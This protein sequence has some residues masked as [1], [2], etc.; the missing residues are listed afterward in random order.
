ML[1]VRKMDAP[2]GAEVLDIDL[3]NPV[4]DAVLADIKQAWA[5]HGIL[6]F[7]N[8]DLDPKQHVDFSRRFGDL[9]VLKLYETYLHKEHPEIFVV[10]NVVENGKNVGLPEAGR[11]WHTD[12]TYLSAPSMGSLLYAREVPHR[13]GKPLGD[14]VFAST[15]AAFEALPEE[16]RKQLTGKAAVHRWDEKRYVTDQ[17][18]NKS[19]GPRVELTDEQRAAI[20][21][22]RHP[23]VR[24][25]P[26]TGKKCLYVNE[27]FTR[28]IDG[29]PEDESSAILAEMFAH[30]IQP[31]FLYR[32]KWAVGD[33]VMWDNCSTQHN[34]IGDYRPD[35][36]R[37]MHRT[38]VRGGVPF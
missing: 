35:E 29:L 19:R 28:S 6:L 27:F 12:V 23:V 17:K 24:T 20:K 2:F 9:E 1:N 26:V 33:L 38:T 5:E 18:S 16:R 13:D 37:L 22:I 36:R 30:I 32:H 21:D 7:R 25:H 14:T 15:I 31:R 8:Q 11:I 4:S 10:S 34:A 3:R